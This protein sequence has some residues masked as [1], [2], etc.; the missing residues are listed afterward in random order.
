MRDIR[1][2]HLEEWLPPEEARLKNTSYN[3]YA[4][5]IRQM[6]EIAVNDPGYC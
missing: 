5:C 2:L 4:G 6:F 3:R 1:P